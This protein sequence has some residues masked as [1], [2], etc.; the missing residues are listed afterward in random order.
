MFDLEIIV[1]PTAVPTHAV[2][3]SLGEGDT[4][5]VTVSPR[6]EAAVLT[7]L[8]PE[9]ANAVAKALDDKP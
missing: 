9:I 4:L 6:V 2:W 7:A 1:D 3:L 8:H 5:R